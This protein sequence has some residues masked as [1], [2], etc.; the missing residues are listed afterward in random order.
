[1][2]R[3]FLFTIIIASAITGLSFTVQEDGFKNLKVLSKKT[4]HDEMEVIMKSFSRS[5]GVKCNFCHTPTADGK[6]LDFASD[7]NK[8]KDVARGMIK[9]TAKINK[10][11]FKEMPNSVTCNTCHNGKEEPASKLP[12]VK[13]D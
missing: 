12:P 9:M 13:E 2:K 7:A 1:M 6:H 10:K 3:Y 8:H 4:T 5:L 11:F